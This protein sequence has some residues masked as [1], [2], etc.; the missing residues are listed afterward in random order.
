MNLTHCD[1]EPIRI[2][3]SI[4]PHGFLLLLAH[5][6]LGVLQAS[7]N[8]G[9]LLHT[10]VE[11]LLGQT[12]LE[13]LGREADGLVREHLTAI[14]TNARPLFLGTLSLNGR[15]FHALAHRVENAVVFECERAELDTPVAVAHPSLDDFTLRAESTE[16]IDSLAKLVCDEVRALTQFDRVLVYRFDET[17]N[18]NVVGESGTGRLPR[19]Y[20][21]WFPASDIPAQA[22]ELYRIN[23]V[24][25]IPDAFYTP[26]PLVPEY[27]PD[28]DE[29]LDMTF[30]ALRSVSPVHVEYMRNMETAS[31]MSISILRDGKLWGLISCHHREPLAVPFQTRMTC[32]L[33]ARTF[34]LRLSGL[35]PAGAYS[36][37]IELRES[38]ARLL[39]AMA[40]R[41]DF[42]SALSDNSA[43]LLAFAK[44][45]GAALL[46]DDRCVLIGRT[47]DEPAVRALGQWLAKRT[48]EAVF[49]SDALS[50]VYPPAREFHDIAAGVMAV[51]VSVR[52]PNY[53][54]W[55]RPEVA[56]TIKWSGEPSKGER[57]SDTGE[58]LISPRKSFETW[59]QRVDGRSVQWTAAEVEAAGELRQAVVN[60][61]LRRADEIASLNA[62]LMQSNKELEAFSY[63]VSHDLRAPLRHIAGYAELLQNSKS[64]GLSEREQRYLATILDSTEYAGNL[65][66]RLLDF[67]KMGRAQLQTGRVDLNTVVAE[68]RHD[69]DRESGGRTIDWNIGNLPTVR[70]DLMML[71][72]LLRNLMEN[73]VKY[74]ARR[75][76]AEITIECQTDARE[77]VF[78]VRDNGVG[79]DMQFADK[80]FGVFQRLHRMEDFPGTGIG[81]ANV[82]RVAERHGGRVWVQAK[83]GEG[84]TFY[85]TLPRHAGET[86]VAS[87][88]A[89]QQS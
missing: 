46:A 69:L 13:V 76:R 6:T 82:Q 25:I 52:N 35:E 78:S 38:Y 43:E 30:S 56:Q 79:F 10:A 81:L 2:P 19:L 64:E 3:G 29:P 72:L 60:T 41:L 49:C 86:T 80:A 73:A 5:D 33:L 4:Q 58:L 85:F 87:Q 1:T 40:D 8:A 65:V 63:S 12:L 89:Q 68:I 44:A 48:D 88:N 53:V 61:V 51:H 22:R 75:E 26:Q 71:R 23:R 57:Y 59:R 54:M 31:S 7:R 47:P 84:A 50:G 16:N 28:T 27:R 45:D 66:D 15:T 32:D 62:E 39:A 36:R 21:H 34:S 70:G 17:W 77:H 9:D 14:P 55:F 83:E 37:R 20:D 18:G 74:T 42:V 67:S 24:R 11:S